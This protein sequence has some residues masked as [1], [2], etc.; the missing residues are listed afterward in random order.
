MIMTFM[1]IIS[2]EEERTQRE[3]VASLGVILNLELN[4][5]ISVTFIPSKTPS[6][7]YI[8]FGLEGH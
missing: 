7:H 4:L 3:N 2:K 1:I 5:G 8:A 6:F